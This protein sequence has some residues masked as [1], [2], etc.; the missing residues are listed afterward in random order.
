ML[1]TFV[2]P[3]V[4]GSGTS[5]SLGGPD[6]IVG[7]VMKPP[8]VQICTIPVGVKCKQIVQLILVGRGY[9]LGESEIGAVCLLCS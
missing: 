9:L 8:Y 7:P 3:P 6:T 5:C 1:G 2:M 4:L